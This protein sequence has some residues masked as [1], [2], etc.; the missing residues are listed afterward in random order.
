MVLGLL[1]NEKGTY[2]ISEPYLEKGLELE[3]DAED[4]MSAANQ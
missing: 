3:E 4:W 1:Y 2:Y